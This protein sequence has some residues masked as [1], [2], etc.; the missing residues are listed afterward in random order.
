ME[1]VEVKVYMMKGCSFGPRLILNIN[2]KIV[3]TLCKGLFKNLSDQM[4]WNKL[5]TFQGRSISNNQQDDAADEVG[6][7]DQSTTRDD[8]SYTTT[9]LASTSY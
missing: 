3:A 2:T 4:C 8:I 6:T 7:T 1:I 5:K 9:F